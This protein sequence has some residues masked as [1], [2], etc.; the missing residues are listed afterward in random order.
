MRLCCIFQING[1]RQKSI[2]DEQGGIHPRWHEFAKSLDPKKLLNKEQKKYESNMLKFKLD[3]VG[4]TLKLDV[5]NFPE[6]DRD[7]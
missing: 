1:Q 4:H 5:V 6:L 2:L 7:A 3:S